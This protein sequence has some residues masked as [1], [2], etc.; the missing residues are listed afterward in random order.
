MFS[1][2]ASFQLARYIKQQANCYSTQR[3]LLWPLTM[4]VD[5]ACFFVGYRHA[6]NVSYN[7]KCRPMSDCFMDL[8]MHTL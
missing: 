5:R 8:L 1:K 6:S 2:E 4:Q 7:K 3:E